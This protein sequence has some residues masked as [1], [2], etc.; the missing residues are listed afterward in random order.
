MKIILAAALAALAL[1]GCKSGT[2]AGPPPAASASA[3][4][5][6][7]HLAVIARF[8]GSGIENTRRFTI[9]GNGNWKLKWSYDCASFGKGN[10]AVLENGLGTVDVNELGLRGHGTT[11]GYGDAGQHYLQVNSECT[12]KMRVLGTR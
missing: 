8:S 5:K 2:A 12:W 10:F 7:H 11:R 6:P 3:S 1:A 9:G 4:A